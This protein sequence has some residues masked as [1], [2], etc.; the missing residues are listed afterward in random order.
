[1]ATLSEFQ[2]HLFISYAHIDNASLSGPTSG[3]IDALHTRL[4][5]RLAMLLGQTPKI[6]R[7]PK[8]TGADAF[9]ETIVIQLAGSA[10]LISVLTPRYLK[11]DSCRRELNDFLNRC[12]QNGGIRL[13][14]KSR[15][16]KV[17]K[18][19]V[20]LDQHPDA[21]KDLLGYQF[22]EQDPVSG[23]IREFDYEVLPTKD[24]RYFDRLE[25]LVQD[26]ADLI[27]SYF[28]KPGV[29]EPAQKSEMTVYLAETTSDLDEVRNRVKRELQQ[30]GYIVLPNRPLPMNVVRL[31]DQVE[32]YLSQSK[33][34]VHFIGAH[35][36]IIPEGELERS[37]VTIQE[38][39]AEECSHCGDLR[40]L[41][42]MPPGLEPVD[43]RQ[44]DFV[45]DLKANFSFR[46]ES[47][48]LQV[49][50]EELKTIIHYKLAMNARQNRRRSQKNTQISI[51]LICD[52][53]DLPAAKPLQHYLLDSGYEAILPLVDG[54]PEET[55][56]DRKQ[57]LLFCDAVLIFYANAAESWLKTQLR[58]LIKLQGLERRVPLL[59]KAFYL[60]AP[61][62]Q[63]KE[64]FDSNMAPVIRNYGEFDPRKLQP[65]LAQ[66][67]PA[68][69]TGQ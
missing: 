29:Y 22:Y 65:F 52:R 63:A 50:I 38:R 19:Y 40:Q 34:S 1:M 8:L 42:W 37:I 14:N 27:N 35:Y 43:I 62:S 69:G 67:E 48:L 20:P 18:T 9:N 16:L 44:K 61:Q 5:Q 49:Q 25:D 30:C 41:L 7:D 31:K 11:S 13:K 32:T 6:W 28:A 55:L 57:N 58:E 60:A 23:R 4:E 12:S 2:N 15:I 36:G 47:E 45:E 46:N 33:L 26:I 21:L 17:M 24:K 51:Y 59:A 64:L 66:L 68:R 54:G 10:L 3:W 53:Q 39:L 56:E